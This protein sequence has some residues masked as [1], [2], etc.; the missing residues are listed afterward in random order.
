[1]TTTGDVIRD[2]HEQKRAIDGRQWTIV[3]E[4]AR[5]LAEVGMENYR[6]QRFQRGCSRDAAIDEATEEMRRYVERLGDAAAQI[7]VE[8]Y[9][10]ERTR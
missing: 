4:A 6:W 9:L 5:Q 1:M 7:M 3:T 10:S 2:A 8:T